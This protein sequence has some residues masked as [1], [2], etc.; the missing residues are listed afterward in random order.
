MYEVHSNIDY[1]LEVKRQR[2]EAEKKLSST[3]VTLKE[4]LD[5]VKRTT[6]C[7]R[8]AEKKEMLNDCRLTDF[9]CLTEK[10]EEVEKQN[11]EMS[12]ILTLVQNEFF[13]V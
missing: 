5:E 12:E 7:A 13:A 9:N 6:K 4:A 11:C 1:R 3:Q 10:L 8:I 2:D